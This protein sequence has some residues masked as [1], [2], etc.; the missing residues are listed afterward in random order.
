MKNWLGPKPDAEL[1]KRVASW[2]EAFAPGN[3]FGFAILD[4]MQNLTLTACSTD[5]EVASRSVSWGISLGDQLA[6]SVLAERP[7]PRCEL[8]FTAAQ[9]LPAWLI[10]APD[11]MDQKWVL[12]WRDERIV[13]ARSRTGQVEAVAQCHI[14]DSE[15]VVDSIRLAESTSLAQQNVAEVFEWLI[16]THALG[17]RLAFPADSATLSIY[18][19]APTTAFSHMLFCAARVWQPPAQFRELR[20]NG[21]L[22]QSIRSGH[23][24]VLTTA[25]EGGQDVNAPSTYAGYSALHLAVVQGNLQA[26]ERHMSVGADAK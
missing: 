15:L 6:V 24:E 17:E 13:A 4:L 19:E 9:S 16:R 25:V 8:R 21:R 23:L 5:P 26:L 12:A 2:I 11:S 14:E 18:E 3:R 1:S 7:R 10:F 22:V 20:S